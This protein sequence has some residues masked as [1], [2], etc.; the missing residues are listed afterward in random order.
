LDDTTFNPDTLSAL[1]D[2]NKVIKTLHLNGYKLAICSHNT[3]ADFI[4]KRL[5]WYEL[6]DIIVGFC[7]DDSKEK[8]LQQIIEFYPTNT[9]FIYFDDM[10]KH[11]TTASRLGMC[12]YK[13]SWKT[14]V[15]MN[16]LYLCN[17]LTE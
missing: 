5:G 14:G 15:T 6:F 2:S 10:E 11:C 13:V 9:N 8:H 17:L 16:D 12:S 4:I 1:P 7:H 3:K